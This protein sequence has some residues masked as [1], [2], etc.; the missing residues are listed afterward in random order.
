MNRN[1][2][3][4]GATGKTGQLICKELELNNLSYSVFVR[5]ESTNKI[6]NSTVNIKTGNVLNAKD[7][8][9]AFDNESFSDVVIALG[10]KD[11][12]GA[13]I[14]AVGT[15]NILDALNSSQSN[16]HIHAISALGVGKSW[17]QLNW[18]GKLISNLLIKSTMNDH[19]EQEKHLMSNALPY[20]IL[21]PVGLKDGASKGEVHV[22]NEG[23]LPS[24][25]IQRADVAKFLVNSLLENKTGVSGICQKK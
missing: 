17:A 16:S 7:V 11:L 15:K 14:R 20:H 9:L 19:N 6:E 5:E 24:N 3:V 18:F 4:F 10:S 2:I 13:G 23:F 25:A 21:R 12:K 1:I 22:Q 8:Q